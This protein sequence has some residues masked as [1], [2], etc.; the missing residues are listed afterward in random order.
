VISSSQIGEGIFGESFSRTR[1]RAALIGEKAY[2]RSRFGSRSGERY[3][4]EMIAAESWSAPDP[5]A[6]D[7]RR[8]SY[9]RRWRESELSLALIN[10][11]LLVSG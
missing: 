1:L 11:R 10:I 5:T 3:V 6:D 9:R 8:A 4:I 2:D 7:R